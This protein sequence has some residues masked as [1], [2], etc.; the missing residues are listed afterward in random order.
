MANSRPTKI[1][2]LTS[3]DVR[4]AI[5][6]YMGWKRNPLGG[7][8][9]PVDSSKDRLGH[10]IPKV[11]FRFLPEEVESKPIPKERCRTT[12]LCRW[13][14]RR[15]DVCVFGSY[16]NGQWTKELEAIAQALEKQDREKK[17]NGSQAT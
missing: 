8:D 13:A 5:A 16:D 9:S 7:W 2:D 10:P 6:L 4:D 3:H 17:A 14:C 15:P 11:E 1:E 12:M